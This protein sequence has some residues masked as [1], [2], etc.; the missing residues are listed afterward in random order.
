MP[1]AKNAVWLF[2]ASVKLALTTLI[3]LAVISIIGTIIKQGQDPSYY[4]QEYGQNLSRF[5]EVLDI[6]NMYSSWWFTALLGIFAL[7]L[8]VCSIERLPRVLHLM[9]QD[10]L[11]I[12][13]RQLEKRGLRHRADSTLSAAAAAE[14]V[15]K[16]MV[17][18]GWRKTRRLDR[19]EA[20]LLFAQKG[21]WSRLGVYIVHLSILVILIGAITGTFFGL[22][23]YV[24]LPEGRTTNKV[25]LRQNKKPVPLGYEL[26][27][28]RYERTF[29]PN[30]MIKQYRVDLT[31]FDTERQSPL[32]KSVIVND[33]LS[34]R[35]FT[36]YQADS[37]PMEEFLVVIRNKTT[38]TEQ[39]FRAPPAQ[40]IAW[41]GTDAFFR[42][43][44]LKRDQDDTVYQAKI[45]FKADAVSKPSVFWIKDQGAET[46]RQSGEEFIFEF[47][48]L[49]S[50][51][52]LVVKDPGVWIVYFGCLLMVV[53]LAIVFFLSHRRVWI[54]I[55]KREGQ[56][57]GS[58]ILISG[59]SNKN[60]PSFER[61][62]LELVDLIRQDDEL[63]SESS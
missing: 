38:G 39:A 48:Q 27:C 2:F 29:Y 52:L 54:R 3:I 42:V 43:E 35:G 26:R 44:D 56:Q 15:Q 20:I 47:R 28:D 55:T 12:D 5:F 21:T 31:V 59:T 50:T 49:Y 30:G 10:N 46:I 14:R 9:T 23:A 1:K 34:Y 37:Y 11:A 8:V 32:Q 36:F 53:G 13:P 62:F 6:T 4:V 45:L 16:I 24:F 7:N 19:E 22:K 51:L 58:L 40:D 63:I 17:G 57:E 41:P 60:K 25:F 33:P 61:K 18:S